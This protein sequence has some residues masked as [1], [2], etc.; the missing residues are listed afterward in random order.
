[1]F[2]DSESGFTLGPKLLGTYEKEVYGVVQ[3]IF[4]KQY[5]TI[6]NLGAGDGFYAV[7]LGRYFPNSHLICFEAIDWK[8]EQIE[9]L[10]QLNECGGRVA[11]HGLCGND[12]LAEALAGSGRTLVVC[13]VE[14]AELALL[15]PA[16]TSR[17]AE[18]DMLVEMHDIIQPGISKAIHNRFEATHDIK[19]MSTAPRTLEDWPKSVAPPYNWWKLMS[20]SREGPMTWSWLSSTIK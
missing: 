11:I 1:R 18:V 9:S 6:V 5:D 2:A 13:D 16:M 19:V 10:A 12:D 14:G 3:Q 7:G 8:H 15:D 20:E 4:Q 17:L